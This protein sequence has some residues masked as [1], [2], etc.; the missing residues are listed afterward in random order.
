MLFVCLFVCLFVLEC[1]LISAPGCNK[2][3][4]F[5]RPSLW[6]PHASP[7]SRAHTPHRGETCHHCQDPQGA[8]TL[9]VEPGIWVTQGGGLVMVGGWVGGSIEGGGVSSCEAARCGEGGTGEGTEGG[10]GR[11]EW[12]GVGSTIAG[13]PLGAISL[14]I[15]PGQDGRFGP[16]IY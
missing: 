7:D 14:G 6:R 4:S 12:K 13:I 2:M 16:P 8:V 10:R 3:S 9:I 11:E 1:V 5:P 15:G